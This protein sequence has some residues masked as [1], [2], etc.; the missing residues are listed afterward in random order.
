MAIIAY[1]VILLRVLEEKGGDGATPWIYALVASAVPVLLSAYL[2][3][4]SVGRDRPEDSMR[5]MKRPF[6]LLGFMGIGFLLFLRRPEFVFGYTWLNDQGTIFLGPVGKAF[7][8]Y[9]LIGIVLIGGNLESTYRLAH[10]SVRHHLRLLFLAF[11]GLLGFFTFII[12]TGILYSTI[13]IGKLVASGLPIAFANILVAY[14]FLRGSLTDVASPISRNVVYSSFTALAA[15]LYVFAVG[16]VAQVATFTHWSPDEVVTLSLGF[17]AILFAALLLF[18]NRFQ[19][20]VRRFIDRNFYVNRYDYR[21]QWSSVTRALDS[22]HT[23]EEI[24]ECASSLCHDVFLADRVTIALVDPD[25]LRLV[26]CLGMGVGDPR[27]VLEAGTPLWDRLSRE[28][29]SL[30][31]DQRPDDFEY[32]PIYA[33]NR[34]WLDS[35]ASSLVAPLFD[36]SSLMGVIGLKRADKEDRFTFEDS[37]LLD[38]MAAHINSAIRSAR[39]T[40]QLAEAR[41]MELLSQ[42]SNMVVHDFKNYLT[43]LRMISQNIVKYRDR[44]DI[45]D[46]AAKDIDAVADTMESLVETLSRLRESQKL[47]KGPVQLNELLRTTLAG[48]Q[49]EQ[50][51]SIQVVKNYEAKTPVFGDHA[52]LRRVF[53]NLLTNAVEAMD[54]SGVLTISTSELGDGNGSTSIMVS[55]ADSGPGLTEDFIQNQLFKPFS[56][57]KRN[58]SGLGLYQC[59]AILRAHNGTLRVENRPG[60]G[61]DFR[62]L[63]PAA[64]PSDEEKDLVTVSSD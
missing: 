31:L 20:R 58:G 32:I 13:G 46:I 26:P 48:M 40:A 22:L 25:G 56:T 62:V 39:L 33:E 41:E 50:N 6:L 10:S 12:T 52:M 8:S 47:S 30:L 17:L 28:R 7:L 4:G 45:V 44:S 55:V 16:V 27:A 11:F 14:A 34:I 51:D 1:L 38:S 64:V 5:R 15:G 23:Q 2:L 60:A 36:G 3:S 37:A 57:T 35:T 19:R 29:N 54:G 63:L 9:L 21:T 18:S 43:P 59:R 42:W 53:E 49:I 61:A 24:L